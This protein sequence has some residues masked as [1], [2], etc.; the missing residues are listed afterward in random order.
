MDQLENLSDAD[1]DKMLREKELYG[2]PL[3]QMTDEELDVALSKQKTDLPDFSSVENLQN[4]SGMNLLKTI[5]YPAG[6]ARTGIASGIG[7]VTDT[8]IGTTD[9]WKNALAGEAPSTG[10]YLQKAGVPEGALSSAVPSAYS[11][12]GNEWFKLKKGG[13][14][15]PTLRG[16]VGFAGDVAT[17]P[18]TYASLGASAL[19]KKGM[20]G[21]AGKIADKADMAM[22]P[23]AR[24]LAN[25]GSAIYRSGLKNVDEFL[26]RYNNCLLYT[27][28]SPRDR[29]RSRMPSSA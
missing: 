21:V 27:S 28:P 7:A 11:D 29:T 24:L 23:L 4:Q 14:L 20:T 18:M 16:T 15:D 17:D 13:M 10:E 12:T 1:L 25:R 2:K 6:L 9:D 5:G 19:A 26:A 3:S 8:P 22:N